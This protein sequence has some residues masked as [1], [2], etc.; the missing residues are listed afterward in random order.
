MVKK[1]KSKKEELGR[2]QVKKKNR[3]PQKQRE[4]E[5]EKR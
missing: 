3:S 2:K 1:P 4:R 5:E